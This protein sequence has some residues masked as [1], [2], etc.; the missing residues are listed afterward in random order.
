ME[1]IRQQDEFNAMRAKLPALDSRL[2]LKLPLEPKLREL[3][4]SEL[5]LVQAVVNSPSLE[6][7]LDI[8]SSTDLETGQAILSLIQRGYLESAE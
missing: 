1:G 3:N 8:V 7:V 6:V 4:P 2:G 5:D